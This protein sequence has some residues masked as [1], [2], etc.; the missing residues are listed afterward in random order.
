MDFE[1]QEI[2]GRD[3]RTIAVVKGSLGAHKNVNVPGVSLDQPALAQKD[4]DDILSGIN[5]GFDIFQQ[6]ISLSAFRND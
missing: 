3:I 5:A 2:I 1:V 4:I 6:N